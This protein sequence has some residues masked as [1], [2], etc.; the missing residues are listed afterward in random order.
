MTSKTSKAKKIFILQQGT[1]Y[2]EK[3]VRR[4]W[5]PACQGKFK[6]QGQM[7]SSNIYGLPVMHL[8][9]VSSRVGVA[10]LP[11]G[12]LKIWGLFLKIWGLIPYP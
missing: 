7:H 2:A 9:M 12:I 11:L 1:Q 3:E 5:F 8:S 6:G 10:G 4:V